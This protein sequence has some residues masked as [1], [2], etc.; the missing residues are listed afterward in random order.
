MTDPVHLNELRAIA[1]GLVPLSEGVTSLQALD[2]ALIRV[3]LAASVTSLNRTAFRSALANAYAEG[4]TAV[5]IQEVVSLVSGLGVHSLMISAVDILAGEA[6]SSEH[7]PLTP[8]QSALWDKYVADNCFWAHFEREMPGFL[9]A[10]LR[11]SAD[12]F[13][14]FFEY[15]GIPWKTRA[16]PAMLKELIAMA[17]D[18]TPAHRFLPGFRLHLANAIKLGASRTAIFETLDLAAESPPH[19]GVR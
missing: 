5:Q 14:A 19:E 2:V 8:E 16:V 7:A 18:A 3:G 6:N 10:L 13:A 4:A 15:C 12:Q 1:N 11:L 9:L 17:T